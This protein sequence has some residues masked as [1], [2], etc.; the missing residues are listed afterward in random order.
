MTKFAVG[1]AVSRVE[2]EPL[3]RGKGRYTDDVSV[4]GMAYAFLLRSPHAH[5]RIVSLDA[6]AAKAAPGV[7]AVLTGEDVTAD[8]LSDMPCMVPI[9]NIDGS[10]RADTPHPILAKEFVRHVGDPV[11]LVVAQSLDQAR[12]AAELIE[13]EYEPRAAVTDA[14]EA[15]RDAAALAWDH[16][17][18]NLCFDWERGDKAKT[19]AALHQ[20]AHVARVEL[21]NNRCVASPMEPRSALADYDAASDRSTLYSSTQGP[22]QV[23]PQICAMLKLDAK[24]LRCVTGNVGGGFGMK[25]FLYAE[26]C[27]VVWASRKLKRAVKWVG[28]RTESFLSDFQGRDNRSFAELALDKDGRFLALKVTTYANLGAYLSN[29]GPFIPT[30]GTVMLAGVYKTPAIY[31]NVKGVLTNTVPVDAYRGAGRPEAIYLVERLVDVAARDLGLTP[32]EIR[33]RNFIT[34][35]DIPYTTCLGDVYDSG[36]FPATMA[37]CM[38]KADWSGFASRQARSA[39]SGKLRGIGLAYY[40]ERCGAGS[41]ETAI[42]KVDPVGKATLILGMQDNGQ[43]HATAFLQI[44][45]ERLGIDVETVTVVQGDTDITPVGMTGG[46]RTL[47]IGGPAV[48]GAAE[49][50]IDKGRKIAAHVLEA[51]ASDIEFNDGRFTIAGTDRTMTLFEAAGALQ[52]PARRPAG[53]EAS[54]DATFTSAPTTATYPNGCHIVEV[55]IDQDTGAVEI[56]RYTIVDDFGRVINP[57]LLAGQVH[58]GIVQGIGQAL[59]EHTVYDESTGQLL[60]ASFMDYALPRAADVPAFDFNMN[61]IPCT[62]NELGVKGAGEAGAIGAPPA[63]I[64]AVVDAL[65]RHC[66]VKHID[67]PALAERVWRALNSVPAAAAA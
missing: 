40:I 14:F 22:H 55:D 16:V 17:P 11:A 25:I 39:Q 2:D 6:S 28:E 58:G 27:L 30:Y 3:L 7:L 20:A 34:A 48:I 64:N 15:T 8:A 45:S 46:S 33:R 65:Y 59:F 24:K 43:G 63:V 41:P 60:S 9:D 5:A 35:A 1:Q 13:L 66:G 36:D 12:D 31:V 23:Q 44:L 21:V 42:L 53:M 38:S 32:D 10:S 49:E 47:P 37:L 57:N 29:Y 56:A 62:A 4:P 54:L 26:S 61:N 51:A 52:D 67:M 50:V 18:R 19:D